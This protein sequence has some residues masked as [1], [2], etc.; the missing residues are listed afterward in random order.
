M[1]TGSAQRRRSRF[2]DEAI[3][4]RD[5]KFRLICLLVLHQSMSGDTSRAW[6]SA[7][8]ESLQVT[9]VP[10]P[11]DGVLVFDFERVDGALG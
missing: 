1:S 8:F 6:P 7:S 5:A 2:V 3:L 11:E 9:H 4:H 10:I